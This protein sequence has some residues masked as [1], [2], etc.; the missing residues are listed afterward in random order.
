VTDNPPPTAISSF[1]V[2]IPVCILVGETIAGV[3]ARLRAA[4]ALAAFRAAGMEAL[5]TA[6][7]TMEAETDQR[8]VGQRA[9]DLAVE[10][11]RCP[12]AA[13]VVFGGSDGPAV[14]GTRGVDPAAALAAAAS[15]DPGLV[16]FELPGTAGPTGMLVVAFGEDGCPDDGFT[17]P[18][19]RVFAVKVARAL[20]QV[21]VVE[22]LTDAALRDALT[23]VG[24]RRH[25][26]MLIGGLK[27]GDGVVIIDL[28]HFKRVNDDLGHAAGDQV[29]IAVGQFLRDNLR[30]IDD[31]ARIGGEEF[32]V[33]LRDIDDPGGAA[34]RIVEQWRALGQP[35]TISA[36]VDVHVDGRT[37]PETV[38][39]ADLALYEAKRAGRDTAVT[40]PV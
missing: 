16:V 28:D 20:E 33:V 27:P 1:T 6:E 29:L 14:I 10:I 34:S 7:T 17:E 4:E 12:G 23:G 5:V 25:A 39:R 37:G 13:V 38:R 21:H 15:D 22:A 9:A 3:V 24:N 19:A 18:A 11:L 26:D 40:A 36:G 35:A 8:H 31:V 32:L 30:R 2:A